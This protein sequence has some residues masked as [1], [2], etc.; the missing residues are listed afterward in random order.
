MKVAVISSVAAAI[1]AA[2]LAH[3]L[4]DARWEV[5][6]QNL[7]NSHLEAV[8]ESQR[9]ATKIERQARDNSDLLAQTILAEMDLEH[10]RG[11]TTEVEV[12][13][14]VE[15]N[16]AGNCDLDYQ[17]LHAHDV[18]AAHVSGAASPAAG[19]AQG[20]SGVTEADALQVVSA[21]YDYCAQAY[22]Q[23]R[24]WKAYNE[25]VLE[26]YRQELKALRPES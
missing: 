8:A 11:Q 15:S 14:Y 23:V 26:P 17:W 24:W 20:P 5:K 6:Y 22:R 19:G 7:E 10:A 9:F 2:W 13:R 18:R 16:V 21:N 1:F 3:S 4:T 25:T 12:I